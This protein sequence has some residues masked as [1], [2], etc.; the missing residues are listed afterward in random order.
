MLDVQAVYG[1]PIKTVKKAE[2]SESAL[3]MDSM[4]QFLTLMI[5][6]LKYQDPLKPADGAD[7]LAQTAQM[8]TVEQLL[9]LNQNTNR[10]YASSFLGKEVVAQVTNSGG[11]TEEVAGV[12]KEIKYPDKGEPQLI[13][14]DGTVVRL[15]EV[16]NVTEPA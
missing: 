1:S 7:Y 11:G 10:T 6:Q 3:G 14:A 12:V 9:K 8:T 15:N 5:S 13:L 4:D 2:N 16:V